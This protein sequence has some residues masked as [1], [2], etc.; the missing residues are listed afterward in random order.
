MKKVLSKKNFKRFVDELYST[1]LATLEQIEER[2]KH[3][4]GLT[5]INNPKY[6][7][8]KDIDLVHYPTTNSKLNILLESLTGRNAKDLL[9]IHTITT[10]KGAEVYP[11]KDTSS[12]ISLS[13]ILEDKFKGGDFYLNN[14]YVDIKKAGDYL[15]FNGRKDSH[16]VTPI[17]EGSRKVLIAFY[18]PNAPLN[19]L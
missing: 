19:I 7:I 9:S 5:R 2:Y 12:A 4:P 6:K 18:K 8:S 16:K 17:T 3:V 14:N 13:L 15:V 11:H 10:F 1:P